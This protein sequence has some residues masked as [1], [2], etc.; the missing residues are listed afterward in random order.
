MSSSTEPKP[1]NLARQVCSAV[2]IETIAES[3]QQSVVCFPTWIN[4]L[5]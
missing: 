1:G 4:T 2:S 3:A 5:V